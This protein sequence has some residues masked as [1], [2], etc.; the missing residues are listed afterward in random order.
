MVRL[1]NDAT[2]NMAA[3]D[4]EAGGQS[5]YAEDETANADPNEFDQRPAECAPTGPTPSFELVSEFFELLQDMRGKRTAGGNKG[6][7]EKKR[8]LVQQM[9][10]VGHP[11]I[12]K[13][14]WQCMTEH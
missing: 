11:L 2:V 14:G 5:L 4:D 8:A 10:A 12:I 1:D 9:F 7:A 6:S 13:S 3:S